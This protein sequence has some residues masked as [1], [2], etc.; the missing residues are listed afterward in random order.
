MQNFN[1]HSHTERCG[2]AV[3]SDEAYV[4]E[5]IRNG[6]RYMG[7][8]DHAP[9]RNG[10]APGERMRVEAFRLYSQCQRASACL[11][12]SNRNPSGDGNRI[13]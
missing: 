3:G 4:K 13:F 11:S 7:F 5:A 8:S 1:Y 12:G 9:Y 10:D 6:Y 2:H